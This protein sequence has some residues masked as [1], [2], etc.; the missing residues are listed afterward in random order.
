M[1]SKAKQEILSRARQWMKQE[2]VPAHRENT[3]KLKSLSEFNINPFLWT[4]L[5]FFLEG[6]KDYISLAKVL[7]YPRVLGASI[8]TSFGQ[9]AQDFI[10]RLFSDNFGSGIPGIDLEFIDRL[11]GRKKYAQVKAGPNVIN[12]DDVTSIKDH[13][14]ALNNLA[15]TNHLDL[16]TTDMV[17]CLLYG[18]QDEKNGFVQE[19]ENEYV[20]IMG[21]EFWHR[22]TGDK[23]F[24]HD[25]VDTFGEVAVEVNMKKEIDE[26]INELSKEIKKEYGEIVT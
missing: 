18:E 1:D 22:F 7:V 13:F 20:V 3:L 24:Y 12:R 14:R 10:T 8:N 5:A 17:F 19:L 25:L 4:Y 2:L 26:V 23:D 16:K 21:Q 6:N 15:R 9:R 11:D